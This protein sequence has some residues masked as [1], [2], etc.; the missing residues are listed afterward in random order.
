MGSIKPNFSITSWVKFAPTRP[1]RTTTA[2]V[3]EGLLPAIP[4]TPLVQ[5]LLGIIRNSEFDEHSGKRTQENRQE[6]Q[7]RIQ[8]FK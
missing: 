5:L 3:K 4:A 6:S 2:A 8:T 1:V 7:N